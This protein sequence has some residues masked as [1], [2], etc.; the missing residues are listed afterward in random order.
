MSGSYYQANL[1]APGGLNDTA[2]QA[3]TDLAG[4]MQRTA[5]RQAQAEQFLVEHGGAVISGHDPVGVVIPG[6]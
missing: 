3:A 2:A 6:E 1:D 5:E 4:T